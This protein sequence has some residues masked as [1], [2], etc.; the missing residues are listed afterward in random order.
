MMNL[1]KLDDDF[2]SR[3]KTCSASLYL[4]GLQSIEKGFTGK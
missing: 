2:L 4:L 3:E 1:I